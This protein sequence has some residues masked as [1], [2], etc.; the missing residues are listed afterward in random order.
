MNFPRPLV[1]AFLFVVLPITAQ[2]ITAQETKRAEPQRDQQAVD[3]LRQ[4]LVVAGGEQ[5]VNAVSDYRATGR[6]ISYQ[7]KDQELQG[8]VTLTGRGVH[9]FRMDENLPAGVR[10]HSVSEGRTTKMGEDGVVVK[11]RAE[12]AAIPSSDAFLHIAPMFPG[13]LAF[14]HLQLAAALKSERFSISYTGVVEIEG[15]R[16][17]DVRV[18]RALAGRFDVSGDMSKYR[19]TD[20][21]IDVVTLQVVMTENLV[22]YDVV[23]RIRYSDY[24]GMSGVLVPFS[25][26]EELG[27]QKI[28]T[29]QLDQIGFNTGLQDSNFEIR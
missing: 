13:G 11:P 28:R 18:Q 9:Q 24:K 22:P 12:G 27:G 21:F 2:Q 7:S 4:A 14:P 6:L 26:G 8:T 5:A 20:F 17:H 29:I 10:S 25:I 23:R 16:L 1:S 19:T 3:I 15:R